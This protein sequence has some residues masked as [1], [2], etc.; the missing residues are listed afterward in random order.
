[1]TLDTVDLPGGGDVLLH[2]NVLRNFGQSSVADDAMVD[3]D[4]QPTDRGFQATAV[5][6]IVVPSPAEDQR[7][8][9]LDEIDPAV[10][11][12]APLVPARIKWFDKAK[13]FGFAN[14]FGEAGDV[15]V[16]VEVVRRSGLADLDAGEALA[17][18]VIEGR[19][20]RMATEVSGWESALD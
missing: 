6:E 9:D 4:I 16:H 7:L 1:M 20:G 8:A 14:I 15:F 10:L 12:A 2:A 19:R 5:H 11:R 3:M 17:M 18:R 13:G